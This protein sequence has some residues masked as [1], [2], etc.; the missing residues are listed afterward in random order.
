M[1]KLVE[2]IEVD[3]QVMHGKPVI[4]GTRI[5]VYVVLNL[6]AGGLSP[7]QV[8]QEYPDLT[9]EDVQ[10][11]LAYAACLAEEEVGVL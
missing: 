3:P 11:C 8:L 10:A 1:P 5:P 9:L 2:R 6:L 4:A 7:E